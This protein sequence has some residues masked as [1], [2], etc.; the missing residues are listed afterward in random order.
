M[1]VSVLQNIMYD[2][3]VF[4]IAGHLN[5]R[6]GCGISDSN[7]EWMETIQ[8]SA[9][10]EDFVENIPRVEEIGKP[11]KLSDPQKPNPALD[12]GPTYKY[13]AEAN[14]DSPENKRAKRAALPPPNRHNRKTCHL[15]IQTDP[16]FW[17]HIYKQ[18]RIPSSG[19]ISILRPPF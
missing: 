11:E 18:V 8:R 2:N 13:S 6:P 9:E 15:Y 4:L 19:F 16:L 12:P 14:I 1:P 7:R 10:P 3:V 17:Q 5:K